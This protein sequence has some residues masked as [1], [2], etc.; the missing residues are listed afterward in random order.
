[1]KTKQLQWLDAAKEHFLSINLVF[2]RTDGMY[3]EPTARISV[4]AQ[5]Q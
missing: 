4:C 3:L 1:M 5:V 2:V